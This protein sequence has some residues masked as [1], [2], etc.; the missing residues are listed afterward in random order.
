M[1][2]LFVNKYSKILLGHTGNNLILKFTHIQT[3]MRIYHFI[4]KQNIK[5]LMPC[6]KSPINLSHC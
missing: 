2:L 5:Y 1:I 6:V 4:Y 3:T